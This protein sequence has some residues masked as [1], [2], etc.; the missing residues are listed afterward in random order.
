MTGRRLIL[1]D[2]TEI[3]NGEAG[4]AD[5]FLWCYITGY[6]L[7]AAASVFFDANKTRRIVFQ[8]GDMEDVYDGYTNCTNLMIDAGG[9]ISVCMKKG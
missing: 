9:N 2:G 4:F 6:T 3:E 8:Y 1:N 7:P 5:G